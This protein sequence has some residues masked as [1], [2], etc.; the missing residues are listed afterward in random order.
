MFTQFHLPLVSLLCLFIYFDNFFPVNR[1]KYFL[2]F[3]CLLIILEVA[4]ICVCACPCIRT[5]VWMP[6]DSFHLSVRCTPGIELR[7]PGLVG[8]DVSLPSEPSQECQNGGFTFQHALESLCP[9]FTKDHAVPTL[10]RPG[11]H[12]C[13]NLCRWEYI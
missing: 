4:F 13:E 3:S 1:E 6:E 12:S 5:L 9:L 2:R 10:H 11:Q 7:S 8:V